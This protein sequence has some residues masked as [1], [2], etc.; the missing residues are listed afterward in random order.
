MSR[1][2]LLDEDSIQIELN[3]RKDWNRLANKINKE[4]VCSNFATAIGFINSVA[5]FAESIDHH[6]DILIYGWNKV[7]ITLQTH[8]KGGLTKLDFDLAEKIDSIKIY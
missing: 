1:P 7:R 4:I 8:D 6:P 3:I 2:N 5:V